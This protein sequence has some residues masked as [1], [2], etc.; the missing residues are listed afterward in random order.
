M[1]DVRKVLRPDVNPIVGPSCIYIPVIDIVTHTLQ[2]LKTSMEALS[3][4]L[5]IEK[6]SDVVDVVLYGMLYMLASRNLFV[7]SFH[8]LTIHF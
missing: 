2:R 8:F 1:Y 5:F 6:G 3:E 4:S 7:L